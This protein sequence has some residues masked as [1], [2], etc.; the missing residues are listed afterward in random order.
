MTVTIE[1]KIKRDE[2]S[3]DSEDFEAFEPNKTYIVTAAEKEAAQV[4]A[5]KT[6]DQS[7]TKFSLLLYRVSE[8]YTTRRKELKDKTEIRSLEEAF[9]ATHV[10]N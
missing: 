1:K 7:E 8:E 9:P 2:D 6:N 10:N 5:E 3:Y 4:N